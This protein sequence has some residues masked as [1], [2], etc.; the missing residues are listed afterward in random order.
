MLPMFSS[1]VST[2]FDSFLLL[3]LGGIPSH[4]AR[5]TMSASFLTPIARNISTVA[6]ASAPQKTHTHDQIIGVV[7]AKI[8][9]LIISNLRASQLLSRHPWLLW[10]SCELHPQI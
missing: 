2:C 9:V 6:S 10:P 1:I 8:L 4:A 3:S 5:W 7:V